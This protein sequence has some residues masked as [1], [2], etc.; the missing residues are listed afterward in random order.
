MANKRRPSATKEIRLHLKSPEPFKVKHLSE[1]PTI[2]RPKKVHAR[3]LL[4]LVREGA[5][6]QFHSTTRELALFR[7]SPLAVGG[8]IALVRNT[9]LTSPAASQTA[10]NVDE[11]SVAMNGDV[12]FYTGNWYAAVSI[13]GA[14]V[15]YS[16]QSGR[17][18]LPSLS[19]GE[20]NVRISTRTA[21]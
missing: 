4:P 5:E 10:S 7:S 15:Q 2:T 18:K 14:A 6:R 20:H 17:V 9:E 3:Q 13:D 8:E 21:F 19:Q 12:V 1:P 16:E 11:P